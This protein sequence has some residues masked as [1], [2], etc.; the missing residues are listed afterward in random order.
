MA[1]I[2]LLPWRAER[3]RQRQ[4]EFV[5][6]AVLAVAAGIVL[7]LLVNMYY[8]AQLDGQR[9]RNAFLQQQIAELDREIVEID[10]L[11][12]QRARLLA[13]KAVIEELQGNRSQMVHLFD[14]LVRTIPDG[15]LLTSLKQEG[16]Q[17][18]LEGRAQSNARVSTYMRA[19]DGSGWMTS[20]QLAVIEARDGVPGLPYAFTL[21]VQLSTPAAKEAGASGAVDPAVAEPAAEEVAQ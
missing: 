8:N 13:R 2:N 6:M 4:K 21:N 20:P 16:Q 1:R 15:V 14:Q 11:D 7:W 9:E 3:R 17:L 18:T 12:R 5:Y 19:L 10:A